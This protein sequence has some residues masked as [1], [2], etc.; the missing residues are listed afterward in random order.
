MADWSLDYALCS[1]YDK[2]SYNDESGLLMHDWNHHTQTEASI[3]GKGTWLNF[4]YTDN[5]WH[6]YEL[7]GTGNKV[8]LYIDG[9]YWWTGYNGIR[10]KCIMFGIA[11]SHQHGGVYVSEL[12]VYNK[13]RV[14][15][16][17]PLYGLFTDKASNCYGKLID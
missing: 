13:Y 14:E 16:I 6:H 10:P 7:H 15:S 5:K 11:G 2:Y 8:E 12:K 9:K 17:N 3:R 1:S 4:N